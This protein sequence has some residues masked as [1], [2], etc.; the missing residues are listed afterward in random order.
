MREI[1]LGQYYKVDSVVHRLDPRTKLFFTVVFLIATLLV[2]NSFCFLLLICG[3]MIYIGLSKVPLTF[4]LRGLKPIILIILF[5]MLMHLF[6]KSGNVIWSLGWIR[7]TDLGVRNAVFTGLRL[8]L[9]ILGASVLTYTTLPTDL[10]DG[11]EKSLHWMEHLHVPVHDVSMMMSIALRFIP[12]L[13]EELNRII[14]VQM[15]R[16]VSFDEGNVLVRL[17]KLVPVIVPLF[18]SAVR[19]SSDLAMAMDARCYHGG[20]GRTKLTPLKYQI[21]DYTAYV[22]LLLYVAGLLVLAIRF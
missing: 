19:R 20:E 12:V 21:R 15:S 18:V 6:S 14:K 11:M 13:V 7:F 5:S 16:G 22:F 9:M 4:M 1:T 10:A 2:K 3:M 8:I 17:K